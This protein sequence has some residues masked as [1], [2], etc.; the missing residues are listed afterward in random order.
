MSISISSNSYFNLNNIEYRCPKCFLVPFINII[1]KEN[2]LFMSIKCINDH[3]YLKPF[4]EMENISKINSISNY[5]C[6]LCE[7][8]NN[9]LLSNIFY[10]CSNCY[11]FYCYKHGETHKLK[12]SHKIFLA[13]I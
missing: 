1:N 8:E 9:K 3:N 10:Y 5:S 2:K 6:V 13:K 4:D 12:E 7:N 11:K